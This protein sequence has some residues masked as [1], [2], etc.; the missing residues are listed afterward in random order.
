MII[1]RFNV[2]NFILNSYLQELTNFEEPLQKAL[3]RTCQGA[4]RPSR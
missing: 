2:T 4:L 3:A 1:E